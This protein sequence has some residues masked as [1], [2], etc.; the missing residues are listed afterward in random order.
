MTMKEDVIYTI[1]N[2][3]NTLAE[4]PVIDFQRAII[5]HKLPFAQEQKA[6]MLRPRRANDLSPTKACP[7]RE[8]P[9]VTVNG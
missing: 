5:F 9:S 4:E 3:R 2:Q 7:K 6:R 8:L 1:D